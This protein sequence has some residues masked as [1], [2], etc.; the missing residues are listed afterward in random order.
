[1][2]SKY[3]RKQA[4]YI[5]GGDLIVKFAESVGTYSELEKEGR[6]SFEIF[7]IRWANVELNKRIRIELHCFW[8]H[9]RAEFSRKRISM[10]IA[11]RKVERNNATK[12]D[13]RIKSIRKQETR[14][15]V[16]SKLNL[17]AKLTLSCSTRPRQD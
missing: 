5:F 14:N 10:I 7:A 8:P 9:I 2:S 1:M 17:I 16:S 3:T 11:I 15:Q 13:K 4:C 6:I 12:K